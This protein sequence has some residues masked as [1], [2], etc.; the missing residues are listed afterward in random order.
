MTEDEMTTYKHRLARAQAELQAIADE[1]VDVAKGMGQDIALQELNALRDAAQAL[2]DEE[3]QLSRDMEVAYSGL[4]TAQ[5]VRSVF[6]IGVLIGWRAA[7]AA[8][9]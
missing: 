9:R 5:V 1:Q 6:G 7:A 4:S 2:W 8:S 3:P